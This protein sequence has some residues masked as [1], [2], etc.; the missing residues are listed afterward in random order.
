MDIKTKN[1]LGDQRICIKCNCVMDYLGVLA[2]RDVLKC[3]EDD[4]VDEV[5]IK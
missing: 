2:G 3:Y 4:I 5:L 1:S